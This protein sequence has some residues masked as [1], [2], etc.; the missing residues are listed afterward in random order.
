MLDRA[1][2]FRVSAPGKV[3]LH[4]EHSV[5]Y[6][7][8]ALAGPINLRTYF[9]CK[10]IDKACFEINYENLEYGCVITLDNLNLFLKEV[11]CFDDLEPMM[12]LYKLREKQDFIFKYVTHNKSH[13]KI[14][15]SIEMAVGVTLYL[16]NRILKS[17]GM[18][19]VTKGCKI[20]INSEI[21]IGA[22]LGSSASYGVCLSGGCY[23]ITQ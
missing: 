3:I 2:K 9:Y 4:G 11:N 13:D 18:H 22:G 12:F 19:E 14:S 8:P 20:D 1:L 5:V 17:E 21:S 15:S 23:V 6:G 7:K 10:A 16:L